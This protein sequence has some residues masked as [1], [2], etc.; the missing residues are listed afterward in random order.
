[1]EAEVV[2]E[3]PALEEVGQGVPKVENGTTMSLGYRSLDE[4]FEH[5][6]GA[7]GLH[8][9]S[10]AGVQIHRLLHDP[11]RPGEIRH[12]LS[13]GGFTQ[14]LV[15]DR[16]RHTRAALPAADRLD[17]VESDPHA[18][19]QVGS[20]ADEPGITVSVGGPG[21]AGDGTRKVGSRGPG[22]ATDDPLQH[23]R[24]HIGHRRVQGLPGARLGPE[25][26]ASPPVD[27][28]F[29]EMRLDVQPGVGEGAVRGRHLQQAH[30]HGAQ[31]Q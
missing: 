9:S 2:A 17:L 11:G 23:L 21:L 16:Q 3:R 25:Q 12:R 15:P 5:D 8:R 20:E 19:D 24:E 14:D 4:G 26:V 30:L 18:A 28:L 6:L 31:R 7:A 27:D 29:Q 13:V 22:A 10:Q 1:M